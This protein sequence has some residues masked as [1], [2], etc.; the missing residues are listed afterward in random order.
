MWQRTIKA[1]IEEKIMKRR[2]RWLGNM[3]HKTSQGKPYTGTPRKMQ[4]GQAKE[5]F[6]ERFGGGNLI[7]RMGKKLEKGGKDCTD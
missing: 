3:L 7:K 1:L 4:E 5:H 6:A 2:W